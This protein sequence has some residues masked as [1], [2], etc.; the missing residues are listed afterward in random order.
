MARVNVTDH[1]EKLSLPFLRELSLKNLNHIDNLLDL[2]TVKSTSS[3]ILTLIT[4][5]PLCVIIGM[6]YRRRNVKAPEQNAD[7]AQTK[8]NG[9][10]PPIAPYRA[11]QI[12][13]TSAKPG[14]RLYQP[15]PPT[16]QLANT[17]PRSPTTINEV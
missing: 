6:L 11:P 7:T 13:T 14:A 8:E 2:L 3:Y 12:T 16:K 17:V 5:A 4:V 15:P 1:H 10:Q 9:K